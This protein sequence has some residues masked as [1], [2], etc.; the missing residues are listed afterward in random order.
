MKSRLEISVILCVL[1]EKLCVL[2]GK[3]N[4]NR[5]GHKEETLDLSNILFL[6]YLA[7]HKNSKRRVSEVKIIHCPLSIIHYLS[8]VF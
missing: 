2:C 1:C 3:K 8:G 4:I 7:L 5:K 6:I